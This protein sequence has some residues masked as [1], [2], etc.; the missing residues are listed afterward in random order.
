[1]DIKELR[2]LL[3]LEGIDLSDYSDDDL[4]ILVNSKS[5]ELNGLL[6]LDVTPVHRKQFVSDFK[7]D[8][9]RL[10]FYPVLSIARILLNGNPLKHHSYHV[11]IDLGLIYFNE[12][13]TGDL[14]IFYLSGISD[15]MYNTMIVPLLRDMVAYTLTSHMIGSIEGVSS[16]REG[17]VS[18]NYDTS[19]S[20]G[21]RITSKI[22]EIRNRYSSARFRL[23]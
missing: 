12:Y 18:I 5:K 7:G 2:L 8:I 11:N 16:I 19:N 9:F 4:E 20:R 21:K 3:K 10:N 6:G 14:E 17:D 1:M 13:V 15:D 22:D 23:L